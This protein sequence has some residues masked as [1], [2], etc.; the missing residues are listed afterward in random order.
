MNRATP[1][2]LP[3]PEMKKSGP[4]ISDEQLLEM[5][6]ANITNYPEQSMA[7]SLL[8]IARNSLPITEMADAST[9]LTPDEIKRLKHKLLLDSIE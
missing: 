3:P 6:E 1:M 4:A 9:T 5:A 7:A 2:D 8:V